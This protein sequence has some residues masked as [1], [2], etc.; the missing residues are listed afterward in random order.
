MNQDLALRLLGEVMQWDNERS[1]QEFAWLQLFSRF[2]YDGY[3]DYVAGLRFVES[4]ASWLQQ[5]DM[6]DREAAYGFVRSRVLYFSERE[7]QHLIE[8]FYP[9]VI[10][11]ML[12][13]EVARGLGLPEY[14]IWSR[15]ESLRSFFILRRRCL[16]FGLSDGARIDVF[17]RATVGRISNEQVLLAPEISSDKW[18]RVHIKL[19]EDLQRMNALDG[20]DA[21]FHYIFLL[22]DFTGTGYTA[23]QRL[24]RFW[25]NVREVASSMLDSDWKLVVHHLIG[26][27]KAKND[28]AKADSTQQETRGSDWFPFVKTSFGLVL[29]DS[30]KVTFENAGSFWALIQKYYDPLIRSSHTDKG[31]TS[32]IRLGFGDCALPVVLEHNTPNNSIALLWSE[33]KRRETIHQMRPLFRRRQRH[34][35]FVVDGET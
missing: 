35:D 2:K 20:K 32:D 12:R 22:D 8:L 13:A 5:F 29:D 1:T 3:A 31:G 6:Q 9:D 27:S 33:S 11:P 34:I 10:E 17:R 30:I 28:L 24:L 4:L 19:Q 25:E 14:L 21:K 18:K 7:I 16:F 26:T 23:S 15:A